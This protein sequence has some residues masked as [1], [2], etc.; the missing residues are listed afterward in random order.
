[1]DAKARIDLRGTP[2]AI[3]DQFASGG[4]MPKGQ[5]VF[6]CSNQVVDILEGGYCG[7]TV[8]KLANDAGEMNAAQ[9]GNYLKIKFL[10][11]LNDSVSVNDGGGFYIK[12][13]YENYSHYKV[14]LKIIIIFLNLL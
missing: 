7:W 14:K 1:M 4:Y 13:K 11:C 5:I 10:D 9:G 2:F 12:L 3:D 8:P 6:S